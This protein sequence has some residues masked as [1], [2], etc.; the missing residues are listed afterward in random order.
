MLSLCVYYT[1]YGIKSLNFASGV[2]MKATHINDDP[3]RNIPT[4]L[5]TYNIPTYLVYV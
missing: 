5:S 2:S 4:F 1:L 3:F